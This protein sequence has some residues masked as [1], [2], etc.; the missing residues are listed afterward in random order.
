MGFRSAKRP[1]LKQAVSRLQEVFA[2]PALRV[3]ILVL[4]LTLFYWPFITHVEPWSG[5]QL[6]TFFFSSWLGLILLLM[7]MG[8]SLKAREKKPPADDAG[9]GER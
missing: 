9:S 4:A 6:F 1:G 5:W 7:G 8:L 2:R 3:M